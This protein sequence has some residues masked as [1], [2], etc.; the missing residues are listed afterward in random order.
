MIAGATLLERADALA[1]ITESPP[2][3]T[4]SYLTP[5]HKRA[6]DLVLGWIRAAGMKADLD[7]V[8]NCAA[9]I[10]PVARKRGELFAYAAWR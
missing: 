7:A 6:S 8:G 3:L 2:A 10:A 9:R 1:A 4:R 5:E